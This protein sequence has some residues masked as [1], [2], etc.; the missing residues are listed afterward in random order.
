MG[1]RG[2]RRI[3]L[4]QFRYWLTAEASI[5]HRRVSR[6]FLIPHGILRLAVRQAPL[7]ISS[8]FI[9]AAIAAGAYALA[10]YLYDR[11]VQEASDSIKNLSYVVSDHANRSMQVVNQSIAKVAEALQARKPDVH[12]GPRGDGG[13]R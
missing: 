7:L 4:R 1:A 3:L 11:Q 6:L 13:L 12:R 8:L 5:G 9:S 10:N 2:T